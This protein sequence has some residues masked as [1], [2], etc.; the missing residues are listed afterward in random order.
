[1]TS[2][3][4]KKKLVAHESLMFLPQFYVG[5]DLW[6]NRHGDME[7][8]C[9]YSIKKWNVNSDFIYASALH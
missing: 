9:F 1:M 8:I 6:R 2:K 3:C 4:G 7:S 5:Y